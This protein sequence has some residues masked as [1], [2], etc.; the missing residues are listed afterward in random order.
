MDL[1]PVDLGSEGLPL[2]VCGSLPWKKLNLAGDFEEAGKLLTLTRVEIRAA[3]F[4][5]TPSW[6]LH[7]EFAWVM[8]YIMRG[9]AMQSIRVV[10]AEDHT[11]MREGVRRILEQYHDVVVVGEAEDGERALEQISYHRPDVAVLD[12]RMPKLNGIEVVRQMKDH[13]PNTKA[14]MLTAYDDNDYVLALM[15]VG[16]SGYILKTA[17]PDDLAA[18]VRGVH[19]GEVILDPRIAGKVAHLWAQAAVPARKESAEQLS[20]RELE[21]L[22]LAANGLRNRAIAD[23]LS[24]SVRTVEGHFGNILGKLGFSS[25]T[26]AILYAVSQDLI[27]LNKEES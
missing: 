2:D 10:L 26:E 20:P 6:N 24:I 12:I 11:L 3:R 15:G 23:T 13:S 25:R 8:M 4:V 22:E 21:V 27:T 17:K 9:S 18:A 7:N 16:A 19:S 14:L 5:K 1:P